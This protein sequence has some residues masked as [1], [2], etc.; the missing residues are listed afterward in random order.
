MGYSKLRLS[1]LSLAVIFIASCGQQPQM[2]Q[3]GNSN[4]NRGPSSDATSAKCDAAKKS[5]PEVS[6]SFRSNS[7][8]LQVGKSSD[9]NL[10]IFSSQDPTRKFLFWLPDSSSLGV[11]PG[12]SDIATQTMRID[13]WKPQS[14]STS[15]NFRVRDVTRCEAL[16]PGADCQRISTALSG[17]KEFAHVIRANGVSV[18]EASASDD[19]KIMSACKEKYERE[20][21]EAEKGGVLDFLPDVIDVIGGF[22]GSGDKEPELKDFVSIGFDVVG[23]IFNG[24]GGGGSSPQSVAE[25]RAYLEAS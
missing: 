4:G 8:E 10:T 21:K 1:I 6:V 15:L 14:S 23:K 20:K 9:Y 12:P 13:N 24:G 19:A 2:Q 22:F 16:Q 25:C 7:G 3:R 5:C 11:V 18:S 17:D